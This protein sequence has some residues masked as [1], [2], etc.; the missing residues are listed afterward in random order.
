MLKKESERAWFASALSAGFR[1]FF[2]GFYRKSTDF[3]LR[4]RGLSSKLRA[5][6][7]NFCFV[8]KLKH[9]QP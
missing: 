1:R 5:N 8:S 4:K 7:L 2:N 3:G 6:F 9:S